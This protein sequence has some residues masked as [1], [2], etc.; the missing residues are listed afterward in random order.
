MVV[1]IDRRVGSD[2]DA[3]ADVITS[4]RV[5]LVADFAASKVGNA[6]VAEQLAARLTASGDRVITT[7][8]KTNRWVR[9]SDMLLTT[10]RHRRDVDA[11]IVDVYS[12][13]AFRWA[14]WTTA[15]LRSAGTP[16]IHV[17]R[18]GNLPRFAEA[19]PDRVK[20]L[21]ASSA[22]VVALSRYLHDELSRYGEVTDQIP[23]PLDRD[24]YPYRVREKAEPRIVWLRAFN[25]M[26][27]PTLGPRAL[28]EL[29]RLLREE[30]N[31]LTAGT[32]PHL[33]MI[34]A[35]QGDGSLQATAAVTER[36][37]IGDHVT[38]AGQVAKADVP[39]RLAQG[40]IFINTT[41][42]DN[43]PI[44]ILEAMA[45]GLCVVTTDVGGLRQLVSDEVDGLVVPRDDPEAMARAVQRIVNDPHLARRLST[46]AGEKARASDW[47]VI[48]PQ[49]R[50][51]IARVAYGRN[52]S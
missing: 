43:V 41:N 32:E 15:I 10:L 6:S 2:S 3:R 36:L 39:Q 14:E 19:Q 7:S 26:Y 4:A 21:L 52:R 23:N 51:L 13:A 5:L 11:A 25:A 37:G 45:C 33:T 12:G 44:T 46:N 38:L 22:A 9:V 35:D 30:P 50:S 24:A 17:L 16:V 49:W 34:G 48:L 31:P 27:N 40:D 28:A 8:D 1:G 42:V 18:G 20:R 29:A 47:S